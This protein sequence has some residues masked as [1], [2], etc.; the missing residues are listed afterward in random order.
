[1]IS[2]MPSLLSLFEKTKIIKKCANKD[3]VRLGDTC[4][5]KKDKRVIKKAKASKK[6][7]KEHGVSVAKSR[8]KSKK[9]KG[10]TKT[11]IVKVK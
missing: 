5:S 2:R 8:A 3:K 11:R 4:V 10:K 6:W 9:N 7:A 1:M